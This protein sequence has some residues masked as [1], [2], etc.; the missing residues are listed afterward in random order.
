LQDLEKMVQDRTVVLEITNEELFSTNELLKIARDK[1]LQMAEAA[2]VASSAKSEFLANMS[3]EIRTPMNGVIGMINLLLDGPLAPEQRDFAETIRTS[4]ES[5]MTIINDIL[6]FSKIEAG[7]MT[8]EKVDFDLRETVVNS[9][10][11]LRPRA[12]TQGLALTYSVNDGIPSLL[13]GDPSRLRQIL[14]N[15]MGNAVKFTAK[16]SVSLDVRQIEETGEAIALRFEVRDTG[17]GMTEAVQKKLFQSFTQGNASTTRQFGGTG[18]GLAICRRLVELMGGEIGVNSRP[19]EGSTFWFTLRL[20]RQKAAAEI[21]PPASAM[22]VARSNAA[23]GALVGMTILL[24][25]DN[26][27][28]QLVGTRQLKRFGLIVDVAETGLQAFE[29]WRQKK[30]AVILMDCQMP[31]MDGYQATQKIR[32]YEK[33]NHLPHTQIIAMTAHAMQGDR[34]LCLA[35]GMDDYISKPVN[36]A[37]LSA[38]LHSATQPSEMEAAVLAPSRG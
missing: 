5:L 32:E 35:A 23:P 34:E 17:I 36:L 28:N 19:G 6:D 29:A 38:K 37:E 26:K 10:A 14:L 2:L 30:Y 1:T 18:L 11:L 12:Q 31:E 9:L 15:L 27:I 33:E 20:A 25:E 24:A 4:G 13:V 21:Q 3:H 22:N 7:K 8:F 16:G